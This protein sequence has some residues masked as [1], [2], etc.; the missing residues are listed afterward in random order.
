M[1]NKYQCGLQLASAYRWGLG[2][3]GV[4]K[5]VQILAAIN[6]KTDFKCVV[7]MIIWYKINNKNATFFW[8][9]FNPF[10]SVEF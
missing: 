10:I 5:N 4:A 9:P 6:K 2:G 7:L 3:G 1:Y 8:L